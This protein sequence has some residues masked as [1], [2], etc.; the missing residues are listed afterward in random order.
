MMSAS[1]ALQEGHLHKLQERKQP[2]RRLREAPGLEGMAD[3]RTAEP[4][5]WKQLLPCPPAPPRP[6]RKV[7]PQGKNLYPRR[8]GVC[9][10]I[11]ILRKNE[12]CDATKEERVFQFANTDF[13]SLVILDSKKTTKR[14]LTGPS[15]KIANTAVTTTWI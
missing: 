3:P 11:I 10:E 1:Q 12:H 2:C 6:L 13:I 8:R 5:S 4:F 15:D 9:T 7:M 14:P